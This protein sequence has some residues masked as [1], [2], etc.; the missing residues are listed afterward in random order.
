MPVAYVPLTLS[1]WLAMNLQ[2]LIAQER[3]AQVAAAELAA[4]KTDSGAIADA[5]RL[6][7]GA[8]ARGV[9]LKVSGLG[10]GWDGV[11]HTLTA[12]DTDCMLAAVEEATLGP[13]TAR[14]H[15][16]CFETQSNAAKS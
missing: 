15:V 9:P 4:H 3:A 5:A 2:H 11:H 16:G 13:S 8:A 10:G 7:S 6:L 12:S 1:L 14:T